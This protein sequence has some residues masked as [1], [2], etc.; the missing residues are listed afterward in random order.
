MRPAAAECK[1][2][3]VAAA[4]PL[5]DGTGWG[6]T[7]IGPPHSVAVVVLGDD[8]KRA[9]AHTQHEQPYL[10]AVALDTALDAVL[11]KVAG[12]AGVRVAL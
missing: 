11:P 7:H 6:Q 10:V 5:L 8:V 4:Q 3:N 9:V 1:G 2:E 12:L